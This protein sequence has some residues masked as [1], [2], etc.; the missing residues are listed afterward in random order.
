MAQQRQMLKRA[1]DEQQQLEADAE[2]AAFTSMHNAY[3]GLSGTDMGAG[4]VLVDSS[5]AALPCTRMALR[6]WLREEYESTGLTRRLTHLDLQALESQAGLPAE[7][8]RGMDTISPRQWEEFAGQYRSVL[9][10]LRQIAPVWNLEEPCVIAGF[11]MDRV[12]TVQALASEPPGTFICRFSM[13]QPGSLVL[14]CKV[15]QGHPNADGDGLVHAIIKIVDLYERR[16]D[17]WIRDFAGATHVLDVYK[18]KRVD[19][20]KV[21][22]SNYTRLRALDV[23]D[24]SYENMLG[25]LGAL[26]DIPLPPPIHQGK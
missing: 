10:L 5:G 1:P 18:Q 26:G 13:S 20:R 24:T 3:N 9:Q 21:F 25:S 12:G 8:A 11:D 7:G 15:T 6:E 2:F 23:L 14:T 17:T 19:K 22:A 4:S 16:V